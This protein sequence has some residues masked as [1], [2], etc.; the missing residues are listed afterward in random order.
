MVGGAV[1][2]LGEA[3]AG[4]PGVVVRSRDHPVMLA[5]RLTWLVGMGIGHS[6]GR[7]DGSRSA[8]CADFGRRDSVRR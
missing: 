3:L 4:E 7:R 2:Q 6:V 8:E 1:S 5:T